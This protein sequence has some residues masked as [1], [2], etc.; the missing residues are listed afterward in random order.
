MCTILCRR[1]LSVVLTAPTESEFLLYLFLIIIPLLI[2]FYCSYLFTTG[3]FVTIPV[4]LTAPTETIY[5]LHT[6]TAY[7]WWFYTQMLGY[8]TLILA[9]YRP[10]SDFGFS[11]SATKQT[12]A[13]LCATVQFGSHTDS[14][15]TAPWALPPCRAPKSHGCCT[16]N[17]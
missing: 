13:R 12:T 6:A 7:C 16:D 8:Y 9:R 1:P 17:D 11:F 4:V 10:K 3:P 5:L 15:I 2:L 14:R